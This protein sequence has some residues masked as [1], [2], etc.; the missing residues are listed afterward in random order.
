MKRNTETI[1]IRLTTEIKEWLFRK[2]EIEDKSVSRI[3]REIIQ[4]EIDK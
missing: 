2:S 1:K 3:I 4:S